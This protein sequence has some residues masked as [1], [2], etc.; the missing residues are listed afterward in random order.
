LNNQV[1]QAATNAVLQESRSELD[2]KTTQLEEAKQNIALQ[3]A[4]LEAIKE[5]FANTKT[6]LRKVSEQQCEL[7]NEYEQKRAELQVTV[8]QVT[9]LVSE[10]QGL[11]VSNYF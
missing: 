3:T 1:E 9:F 11:E 2:L 8:E 6:T 7:S 5:E 10:K 4:E